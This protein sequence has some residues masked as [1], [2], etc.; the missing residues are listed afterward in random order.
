ML[1]KELSVTSL[2]TVV[3]LYLKR[4]VN[5]QW[6]HQQSVVIPDENADDS[7]QTQDDGEERFLHGCRGGRGRQPLAVLQAG[8]K[9]LDHQWAHFLLQHE[10]ELWM[11][12]TQRTVCTH[13]DFNTTSSQGTKITVRKKKILKK[14]VLPD[15]NGSQQYYQQ[16]QNKT[17]IN[18]R[19]SGNK[20]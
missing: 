14:D 15:M 1:N 16:Q 5:R 20:V 11:L 4:E 9:Q 13:S 18:N 12:G 17:Q 7:Q 3:I 10:A 6:T 19:Q 8:W 2:S